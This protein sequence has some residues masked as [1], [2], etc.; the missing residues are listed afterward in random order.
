MAANLA[1]LSV[2]MDARVEALLTKLD[3]ADKANRR[4]MAKMRKEQKKTQAQMAQLTKSA[5]G[6]AAGF[7]SVGAAV[8]TM[9]RAINKGEELHNL[10]QVLNTSVSDL[11]ALEHA[12]IRVGSSFDVFT[13]AIQR[14]GEHI[15]DVSRDG[16]TGT[17]GEA[18]TDLGLSFEYVKNSAPIDVLKA[19]FERVEQMENPLQ[20][21]GYLASIFGDQ[22]AK[23]A[24]NSEQ[25]IAALEGYEPPLTDEDASVIAEFNRELK[26]MAH[27]LS[28]LVA[29]YLTPLL[30]A[31]T[32]WRKE[33]RNVVS[34]Q[35]EIEGKMYDINDAF[36]QQAILQ[37]KQITYYSE[38]D[39]KLRETAKLVE[40]LTEKENLLAGVGK[41]PSGVE[42]DPTLKNPVAT[43]DIPQT[44]EEFIDERNKKQAEYNLLLEHQNRLLT[45]E[46]EQRT[47]A[48]GFF[49]GAFANQNKDIEALQKRTNKTLLRNDISTSEKR[50]KVA[51]DHAQTGLKA[52]SKYS[53][54]AFDIHKKLSLAQA[55]ISGVNAVLA[56]IA[57]PTIP[58][59][60]KPF[61]VASTIALTAV[62]IQEISSQQFTPPQGLATGG[63]V[64]EGGIFRVR[65]HGQEMAFLPQGTAVANHSKTEEIL[66]QTQNSSN[67][68]NIQI[69]DNSGFANTATAERL[70]DDVLNE[71]NNSQQD[72]FNYQ[73]GVA[74]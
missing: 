57:D 51:A 23:L 34:T 37:Q 73:G 63:I 3:K 43:E 67:T 72:G 71:L 12:S 9:A 17:A 53:K 44:Y 29:T 25:F 35:A 22:M 68:Y 61:A 64:K 47:E 33:S 38:Y 1:T 60:V 42:P 30:K 18:F 46:A 8:N 6:L 16:L 69:N 27:E 26:L 74:L 55:A 45:E 36:V 5:A 32:A 49:K 59:V 41:T 62:Q 50:G 66:N 15:Q 7:I 21:Q 70:G 20:R 48:A 24:V 19:V 13:D 31:L 40:E 65:E 14:M 2:N 39:G 56:T 58:Y 52:M 28:L 54:T 10:S 11:A 4:A